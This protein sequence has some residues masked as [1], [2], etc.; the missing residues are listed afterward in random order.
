M[1]GAK[2]KVGGWE[3]RNCKLCS[4]YTKMTW[5][6]LNLPEAQGI[7]PSMGHEMDR[8]RLPGSKVPLLPRFWIN[9]QRKVLCPPGLPREAQSKEKDT[10]PPLS[11]PGP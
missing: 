1:V 8:Q 9:Q 5:I 10:Q 4:S 2:E 3:E 7:S 6:S 11:I